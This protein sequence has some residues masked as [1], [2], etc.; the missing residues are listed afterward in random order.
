LSPRTIDSHDRLISKWL[1]H[2]GGQEIGSI[3][4]QDIISFI[5]WLRIEYTPHRY[6]GKTHPLSPKTLRNVWVTLSSFYSWA[7]LELGVAHIMKDVPAPHAKEIPIEPLTQ[8]EVQRMLKACIYSREA[9][10]RNRRS[11]IMRLPN[12]HRDQVIILTLLDTGLREWNF[13]NC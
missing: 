12:S 1:E 5:S 11:F 7:S 6:N 9:H 8:E 3:S 10:P 4:A 13:G 2:I